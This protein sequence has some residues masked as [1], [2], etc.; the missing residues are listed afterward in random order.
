MKITLNVTK[1]SDHLTSHSLK[2]DDEKY[3]LNIHSLC[4]CSEDAIIGRDLVD[5]SH[6]IKYMEIAY[7]AGKNGE[8][9]EV[10]K[11]SNPE[12]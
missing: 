5:G 4:D 8:S 2:I 1:D 7:M 11:T 9:F 6:I 12:N 3:G 10:I